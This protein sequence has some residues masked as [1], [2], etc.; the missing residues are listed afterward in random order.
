[1]DYDLEIADDSEG[2][3]GEQKSKTRMV[4]LDSYAKIYAIQVTNTVGGGATEC[5]AC[6]QGTTEK[7]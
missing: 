6:P 1:M 3:E 5:L 7:G 2:D 4:G